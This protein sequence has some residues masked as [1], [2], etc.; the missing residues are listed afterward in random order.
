MKGAAKG[1]AEAAEGA[2][3]I[4]RP[5][6]EAEAPKASVEAKRKAGSRK[7]VMA[8]QEGRMRSVAEGLMRS[9]R[10]RSF[11]ASAALRGWP[12]GSQPATAPR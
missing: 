3:V 5:Y 8:V 9:S 11:A 10:E 4:W 6:V 12:T 1:A 7:R 2:A